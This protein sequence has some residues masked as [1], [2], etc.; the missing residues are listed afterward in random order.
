MLPAGKAIK[1]PNPNAMHVTIGGNVKRNPRYLHIS[2]DRS[3]A[4][5]R[6]NNIAK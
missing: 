1:S 4:N 2:D 3:T 5:I 6:D